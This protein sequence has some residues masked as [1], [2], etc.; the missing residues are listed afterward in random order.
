VTLIAH[1]GQSSQLVVDATG[2]NGQFLP[3]VARSGLEG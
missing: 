1:R 2:R 3:A